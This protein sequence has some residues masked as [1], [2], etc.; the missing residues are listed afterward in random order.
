MGFVVN[1]NVGG[2]LD[3]V[4]YIEEIKNFAQLSQPYNKMVAMSIP[5][6]SGMYELEY[7]SPDRD[8]ELIALVVTCSGYGEEDYYNLYVNNELWFETWYPT[9][10]KEGLYI[11]TSTY[12]YKLEPKTKFKLEFN[13][14]SG[15]SKKVWLGI[16][17]LVE[18]G[19]KKSPEEE[20]ITTPTIPS[21]V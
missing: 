1:Y 3:K 11:G 4:K 18:K 8:V 15:T 10:V 14:V 20:N 13:N 17:M 19:Y 2:E 6:I 12:V 5:A 16:R 21:G 9:E 7:E